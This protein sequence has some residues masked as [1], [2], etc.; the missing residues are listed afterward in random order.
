MHVCIIYSHLS[1]RGSEISKSALA[2][3][4]THLF[5]PFLKVTDF[6]TGLI[7]WG[8]IVCNLK[9]ILIFREKK[10]PY[11][12]FFLNIYFIKG[13]GTTLGHKT[14]RTAV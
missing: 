7:V 12:Y 1:T 3:Y 5:I 9:V 13:P 4:E 6:R 8:C 11:I 10:N 2:Q 14:V